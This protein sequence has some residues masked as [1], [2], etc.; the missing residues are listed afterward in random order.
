MTNKKIIVLEDDLELSKNFLKYIN[1][2]LNIYR[3]NKKVASIH[4]WSFPINY[5]K[6]WPDYFFIR[7]ADCWGWGTWKRAWK[8][9]N[10]DGKDLVNK[11]KRK[12]K[13]FF[14]NVGSLHFRKQNDSLLIVF[15]KLLITK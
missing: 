5:K 14:I 1:N 8:K 3:N 13:L 6:Y 7:G 4:G 10:P 9:F 15:K 2:G 12:N 11:I